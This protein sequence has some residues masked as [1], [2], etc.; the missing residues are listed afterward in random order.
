MC[1]AIWSVTL[2]AGG[3]FIVEKTKSVVVSYQEQWYEQFV[4]YLRTGAELDAQKS[5]L[6]QR[7]VDEVS[8]A[9]DG[10]EKERF[11]LLFLSRSRRSLLPI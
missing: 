4:R 7:G 8:C 11:F 9:L 6:L 3:S 10:E 2:L 1:L 5:V